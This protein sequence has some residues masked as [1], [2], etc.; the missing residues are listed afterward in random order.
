MNIAF[1]I[2]NLTDLRD[3]FQMFLF[4]YL[5]RSVIGIIKNSYCFQSQ[6]QKT[7]NGIENNRMKCSIRFFGYERFMNM[8]I[9]VPCSAMS[10]YKKR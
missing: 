5:K 2:L 7:L 9:R 4:R 3:E 6:L 10:C 8:E 1:D